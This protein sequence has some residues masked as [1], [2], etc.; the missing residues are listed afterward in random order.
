MCRNKVP[1]CGCQWKF[2]VSFSITLLL[3]FAFRTPSDPFS[4]WFNVLNRVHSASPEQLMEM[5]H[6]QA[7]PKNAVVSAVL[8]LSCLGPSLNSVFLQQ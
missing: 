4:G 6:E 7:N 3:T 5:H 8:P 1:P 2:T